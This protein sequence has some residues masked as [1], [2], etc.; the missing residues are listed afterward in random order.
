MSKTLYISDLDGT[1]LNNRAVLSDYTLRTLNKMSDKGFDFTV[2]TARTSATALQMLEDV[3][4][5]LPIILMNGVII[6]DPLNS[7]IIKKES[8]PEKALAEIINILQD[9]NQHGFMYTLHRDKLVTYYQSLSNKYMSDFVEERKMKFDKVF[10]KITNY[11]YV[12]DDVIYFAFLDTLVNIE[13][14][15]EKI[16]A[17]EDVDAVKYRDNYTGNLWYLEVFNPNASKY[18][19]IKFL[20]EKYGYDKVV[21]F[22]DNLN[23]IAMF[24][25][26]DECYATANAKPELKEMADAVI[27]K[28]DQNGVAKWLEE[29]VLTQT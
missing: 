23:D 13:R 15:Y 28:N 4:L 14:L 18:N 26:C 9:T 29:N 24:N 8:I 2:A 7:T 25:A 6:Y 16:G 1:L 19:G 5:K 12:T 3:N 20:R 11:S 27:G 10:T 21:C 17:I 22:G